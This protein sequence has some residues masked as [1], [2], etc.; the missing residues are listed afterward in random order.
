MAPSSHSPVLLAAA[1]ETGEPLVRR[2]DDNGE[3]LRRRLVTYH[4]QTAPLVKYYQAKGIHAP[5]SAAQA[6][7]KVWQDIQNVFD[8]CAHI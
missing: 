1:Q 3:T 4:E 7:G 6:P 8:A 2:S 5:I